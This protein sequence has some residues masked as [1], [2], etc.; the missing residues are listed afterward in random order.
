MF[1]KTWTLV[2]M[3]V[4]ISVG[5]IYAQNIWEEVTTDCFDFFEGAILDYNDNCPKDVI[6]PEYIDWEEVNTIEY[7]AFEKKWLNSIQLPQSIKT[8]WT[9]G[10][11]DNNLTSLIIPDWVSFIGSSAFKNNNLSSIYIPN[12]VTYIWWWAFNNNQLSNNQ[13]FIY[14]R[15][16][17]G[18]EDKTEIVSYGWANRKLVIIPQTVTIIWNWAFADNQ[19]KE[20]NI[21]QKV[22]NIWNRAFNGNLFPEKDAFIYKRNDDGSEDFTTLIGYAWGNRDS[23]KIP[24]NVVVIE[25][26]VFFGMNLQKIFIPEWVTTIWDFA[27]A[28]NRVDYLDIPD[29]VTSIWERAFAYNSITLIFFPKD[30]EILWEGVFYKNNLETFVISEWITSI[31]DFTFADNNIGLLYL[32][33]SLEFIGERAFAGN[34][35][36]SLTIPSSVSSIWDYAFN[37]NSLIDVTFSEWLATIG[38]GSFSNNKIRKINIPNSV[39]YIGKYAFWDW[40]SFSTSTTDIP[41]NSKKVKWII[42]KES[43]EIYNDPESNIE[44]VTK[45]VWMKGFFN[46]HR[47]NII[48]IAFLLLAVYLLKEYIKYKKS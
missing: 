7:W 42:S 1:K 46:I 13:A 20:M 35:I 30:I 14:K 25:D 45:K 27:F 36:E 8:I 40:L 37:N 29:S 6:I 31:W 23:I 17:R 16:F 5:F 12:S 19:I 10:F 38:E 21:P 22:N 48:E 24:E 2:L 39:T 18:L 32:P 9:N 43:S 11:L 41:S 33:S 15:D 4:V 47:N 28:N 3:F 26:W 44:L 34:D